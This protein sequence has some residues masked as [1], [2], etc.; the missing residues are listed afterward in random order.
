MENKMNKFLAQ[1]LTCS[2]KNRDLRR[3]KRSELIHNVP[4]IEKTKLIM[5]LLCKDEI[6][7]IENNILFH[8]AMGVDAFIVTD[9]GSTDGT[10]E[11]L[12][13]YYEAGIILKI[14]D[15]PSGTFNQID[16][17]NRMINLAKNTYKADWIISSDADEFWYTRALNL[18]Q[19]I[20]QA[21]ISNILLCPLYNY[22]PYQNKHYL[23][24]PHFIQK[25]LLPF[26]AKKYNIKNT[27]YISEINTYKCIIKSHDFQYI[28]EGN[29]DAKVKNRRAIINS[30]II[31]FHF[32]IR[33][34]EH[35]ENKV[36]KGGQALKN[37]PNKQIGTHWRDWYENYYLQGKLKDLYNTMFSFEDF[38]KLKHLGVIVYNPSLPDF[39]EEFI[40]K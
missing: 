39:F 33:N 16:W 6:D 21:H 20:Y 2:I 38:E 18:K 35:F 37:N 9:N 31:I 3:Q 10:R 27:K 1:L 34:Y 23:D 14:F 22:I 26:E 24:Q 32:A 36:I 19:T 4:S 15:E 17:C 5:C 40:N 28:K 11:I 8:K 29:H 25:T 13:K 12:Q 30:D 7:I